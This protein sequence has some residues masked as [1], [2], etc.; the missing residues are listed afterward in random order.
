MAIYWVMEVLPLAVTA[1]LPMVLYP[2][3]GL[4]ASKD[5]ALTYLPV[6]FIISFCKLAHNEIL[7]SSHA[8]LNSLLILHVYL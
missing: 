2:L 8:N 5:V 1:L 4:M 6:R 3:L 7:Q